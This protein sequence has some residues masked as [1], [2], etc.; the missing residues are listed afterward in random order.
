MR[1][2]N[3]RRKTETFKPT[4][5]ERQAL[6]QAA[7]REGITRSEFIRRALRKAM[8]LPEGPVARKTTPKVVRPTGLESGGLYAELLHVHVRLKNLVEEIAEGVRA[9]SHNGLL[10]DLSTLHCLLVVIDLRLDDLLDQQVI[11]LDEKAH[12][13]ALF[14]GDPPVGLGASQ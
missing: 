12:S 11:R 10:I 5:E 8:G 4:E 6:H 9:L 3:P 13:G 1:S 2:A 14:A 7:E